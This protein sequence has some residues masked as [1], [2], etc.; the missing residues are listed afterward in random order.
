MGRIIVIDGTS[1]A[2]KTSLCESLGKKAENVC[3][4]PG[5]SKF[6]K[7]H[8]QK[9]KKVPPIP[10]NSEEEKDNQIFFFRLELDRLIEANRLA[11]EGKDVVMDRGVLEIL[12]VA[13]SFEKIYKWYGI[14]KNA[15]DLY[16]VFNRIVEEKGISQPNL[17]I[18]LLASS[19]TIRRRNIARQ[20]ERGRGL[21]ESEWI[22]PM[23]I[24]E[25]IE[26]FDKL[27]IPE[28]NGIVLKINT[29]NMNKVQVTNYVLKMLNLKEKEKEKE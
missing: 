20:N 27:C 15:S 6:A 4:I 19:E 25:Q 26:F 14:Y 28:N 29:E 23:L 7:I 10:K 22:N 3:I 13:Y 2:G 21:S 17:H 8:L 5:A 24:N 11:N 12:S 16:T 9:Y 18:W 1:N